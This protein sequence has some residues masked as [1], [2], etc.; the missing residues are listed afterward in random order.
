MKLLKCLLLFSVISSFKSLGQSND[1]SCW[2]QGQSNIN[3][4]NLL[5]KTT[6]VQGN[7]KMA[8]ILCVEQGQSKVVPINNYLNLLKQKTEDFFQQASNGNFAVEINFLTE[9]EDPI[10]GIA[11]VYELNGMLIS[12]PPF[13]PNFVMQPALFQDLFQRV[14]S[15]YNFGNYDQNNDG[16]VDFLAL[17][18]IRF[19]PGASNGTTGLPGCD[20]NNYWILTNDDWIVNGQ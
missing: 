6:L 7:V 20:I 9:S 3:Q 8:V 18:V 12:N 13:G 10:N 14:D 5:S 15:R 2:L 1:F 17:I 16:V 11:N 4:L 19:S